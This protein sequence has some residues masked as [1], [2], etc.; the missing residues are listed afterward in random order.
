ME[1]FSLPPLP[2][3]WFVTL[4]C[5][6]RGRWVRRAI[7][8]VLVPSRFVDHV[9]C[10]A[11]HGTAVAGQSKDGCDSPRQL[12]LASPCVPAGK[13][14]QNCSLLLHARVGAGRGLG[15]PQVPGLCP[16]GSQV[17][18]ARLMSP[19]GKGTAV[20]SWF[21]FEEALALLQ[22]RELGLV[23]SLN[24]SPPPCVVLF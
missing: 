24:A 23:L 1:V 16:A 3:Q 10:F 4:V 12:L 2:S 6:P 5:A 14:A 21:A 9:P 22:R 17:A 13:G 19:L 11:V 20:Q 8:V 15:A 18:T 7:P